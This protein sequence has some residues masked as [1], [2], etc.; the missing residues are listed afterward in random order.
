MLGD[1]SAKSIYHWW[2]IHY[3]VEILKLLDSTKYYIKHPN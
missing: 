3:A 2:I 1:Q